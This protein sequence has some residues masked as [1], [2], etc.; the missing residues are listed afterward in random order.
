M[1]PAVA[2]A[3]FQQETHPFTSAPLVLLAR[4]FPF[5]SSLCSPS[6][7]PTF[8]LLLSLVSPVFLLCPVFSLPPSLLSLCTA[9]SLLSFPP[10]L[11][12]P[13]FLLL[14]SPYCAYMYRYHSTISVRNTVPSLVHERVVGPTHILHIAQ[15]GCHAVGLC[16]PPVHIQCIPL[17]VN[18]HLGWFCSIVTGGAQRSR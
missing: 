14:D 9:L 5:C 7:F 16:S 8:A 10:S 11:V 18:A 2:V 4:P 1:V 15:A 6:R 17:P 13:A 3:T 12:L